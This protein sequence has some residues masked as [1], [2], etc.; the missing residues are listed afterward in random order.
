MTD[1]RL[2]IRPLTPHIGAEVAAIG[3]SRPLDDAQFAELHAALMRHM[4]LF[5]RDQSLT[6]EQHR[7]FGARSGELLVHPGSP[8]AVPGHP[9]VMALTADEASTTV[10]GENCHT[11]V[12]CI[13]EP[14]LGRRRARLSREVPEP[15]GGQG[16]STGGA[17]GR[18]DPSGH[19]PARAVRQPGLHHAHPLAEQ[20]R[21]RR[22]A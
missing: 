4:T 13:A 18:A 5:F 16:L 3:L 10:D 17:P 9:D 19:R 20:V 6:V 22:F 12:S 8:N 2:T 21:E 14:P 11:D 15:A 7:A 1:H